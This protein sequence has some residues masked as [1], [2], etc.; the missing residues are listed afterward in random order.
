VN[1]VEGNNKEFVRLLLWKSG[2][3]GKVDLNLNSY[4]YLEVTLTT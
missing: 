4:V 3:K 2:L 1:K